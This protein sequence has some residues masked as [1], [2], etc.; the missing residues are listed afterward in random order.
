MPILSSI[1]KP[2][3]LFRNG[4]FSTIYS[5]K[6]RKVDIPDHQ[7]ERMFL[8]DGDFM[9]LDWYLTQASSGKLAVLL[10]GLEGN[11]QRP[12]IRGMVKRLNA[13][14]YDAVA[15]NY[16][17]C[18]GEPNKLF[19]TYNAGTT[20]DLH[21]VLSHILTKDKYNSIALIGFSLGGNLLLKYLGERDAPVEIKKGIAIST[22]FSLRAS[23]EELHKFKNKLYSTV[24]LSELKK[25]SYQ[26]AMAFPEKLSEDE[27][28]S[29]KTLLDFDMIYTSKAYGY[30]DAYQ[31]Y[32]KCSSLSFLPN[33][34]LPVYILNAK[35]D[36]FLSEECY[37]RAIAKSA[38]NIYLE[39]PKHGGHVG[40][41][42]K[43]N[44]YY[45]ERRALSFL[46]EV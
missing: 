36:S 4:H 33:I 21:H 6:F 22:P 8:P 31:Y 41:Y 40:F 30:E 25:K 43:N 13:K 19:H 45:N 27:V 1:Y 26:K 17:G 14:G 11:A 29:I 44:F 15:V 37:P 32:E 46:K 38:K 28:K 39:T 23:V 9:D 12:Y 3:A 10:H 34:K 18:S 35:N 7:R 5:A 20:D 24:F 2:P 16:R 42:D